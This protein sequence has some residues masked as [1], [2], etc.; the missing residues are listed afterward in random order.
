MLNLAT[1]HGAEASSNLNADLAVKF[2]VRMSRGGPPLRTF[3]THQLHVCLAP[4][5][6]SV[7]AACS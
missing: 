2:E 3:P 1:Q 7:H 4:S 6:V 5:H